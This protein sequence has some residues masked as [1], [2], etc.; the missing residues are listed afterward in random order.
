MPPYFIFEVT[1]R[2]NHDCLFC[3]NVWKANDK[4]VP[5]ELSLEQIDSL[6]DRLLGDTLIRGVT[7]SGGEALLRHDLSEIITGLTRKKIPVMISTNGALLDESTTKKMVEAGVKCF[8]LSLPSLEETTN[9]SL[10]CKTIFADAK[11]A[12]LNIKKYPVSVGAAI[13]ITRLNAADIAQV[14]DLCAAFSMDYAALNRCVPGGK[15]NDY[16][17]K[18]MPSRDELEQV[19]QVAAQKSKQYGLPVN[20]T[21][22]IESC[23]I[24]QRSYPQLNFGHCVCAEEKWA[25]DPVGNLRFCEQS[26]QVL[27]NLFKTRFSDLAKSKPVAAFRRKNLKPQCWVCAWYATCG[28]G[29]RFL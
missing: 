16:L 11:R 10:G 27:G 8:E 12:M 9:K 13:T 29:C 28:G 25:I 20:V 4:E 14:I 21:I 2:C 5:G 23:L 1:G 18:L 22:P 24:D 6:F 3:Y 26:P 15:S 7:L 17:T 19:L